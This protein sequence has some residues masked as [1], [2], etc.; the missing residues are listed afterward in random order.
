MCVYYLFPSLCRSFP[1]VST[2]VVRLL[3]AL[4]ESARG[5]AV[6]TALFSTQ[7]DSELSGLGCCRGRGDRKPQMKIEVGGGSGSKKTFD[8]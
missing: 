6:M 1:P 5:L 7:T 2:L 3:A 8:D 4:E